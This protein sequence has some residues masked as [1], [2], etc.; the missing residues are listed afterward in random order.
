MDH[1]LLFARWE[2]LER[3]YEVEVL[4]DLLGDWVV[5]RRWGGKGSDRHGKRTVLIS[6]ESEGQR[7]IEKV[8]KVRLSRKTPYCRVY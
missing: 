4:Y 8:D 1:A 3:W 2:T 7:I 6:D 5:M